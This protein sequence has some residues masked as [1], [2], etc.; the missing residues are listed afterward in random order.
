MS[1]LQINASG[2]TLAGKSTAG[3]AQ[4]QR[5]AQLLSWRPHTS[6]ELRRAGCY[7]CPTRIFE[8][9]A[10]GFDIR[11]TRVTITDE[12]GFVHVG[13]ALYE[14]AAVPGGAV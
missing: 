7:Q 1:E 8:L 6:Y 4:R 12:D 9:R 11:T 2:R 14:L 10:R 13:V 3:E 5:I